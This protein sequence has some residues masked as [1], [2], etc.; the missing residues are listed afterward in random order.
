MRSEFRITKKSMDYITRKLAK[1]GVYL[2]RGR[3]FGS[4]K[5]MREFTCSGDCLTLKMG[6]FGREGQLA[7]QVRS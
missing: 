5:E 3:N 2:L 6:R 4:L 1:W 7:P